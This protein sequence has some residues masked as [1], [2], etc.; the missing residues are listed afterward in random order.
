[1]ARPRTFGDRSTTSEVK[2]RLPKDKFAEISQLATEAGLAP[3]DYIRAQLFK[4][5]K[6]EKSKATING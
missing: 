4:H 2:L 1:M 5:V 6:D 3:Q